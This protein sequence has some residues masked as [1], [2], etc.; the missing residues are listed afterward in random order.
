MQLLF[1]V[2]VLLKL[3]EDQDERC[4]T[5]NGEDERCEYDKRRNADSETCRRD[6]I[7]KSDLV[8]AKFEADT[9]L[10][11]RKQAMPA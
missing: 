10:N 3:H 9:I 4:E 6:T 7:H 8:D 11:N 2:F 5:T 1:F